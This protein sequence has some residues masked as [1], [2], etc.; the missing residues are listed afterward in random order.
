[1]SG[2]DVVKNFAV[3]LEQDLDAVKTAISPKRRNGQEEGKANRFKNIRPGKLP[4]S[5][6][7][8]SI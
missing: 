2:I 6:K 4:S 1:M 5:N 7:E 8:F 3:G